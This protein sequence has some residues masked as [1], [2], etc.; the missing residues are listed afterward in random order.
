MTPGMQEITI[1]GQTNFRGQARVFGIYQEDRRGHIYVIGKTGVGKSTLMRNMLAQDIARGKGV[2]LVDPHGDLATELLEAIPGNRIN[3]VV[4]FDPSDADYPIGF[5]VLEAPKSEHKFLV[6]SGLVGT[7]K[8]IWADSWGPRLEYILRNAILALLDYP[9]ATMLGI[10]RMLSDKEY[11]ARVVKKI[12]DP[13]VKSFWLNEFANYSERFANEAISPVQNKVGQFLSSAII[14]NIVG[15]PKSTLDIAEIMNQGKV[16]IMNLSKGKIG[17][18]NSALLGAMMI[19]RLQLTAMDRASI[20]EAERKDFYLYVDEFQ[21]FATES[22]AGILS[23]ARKYH[24]NLT[25]AHQYIAQMEEAVRDAVFGNVGTLVTYR[26]G[27]YDAEYLEKEFAPN[28]SQSD[29]VNLDRYN[30]YVRLMING[31]TSKPFSM[32]NIPPQPFTEGNKE[33]VMRVSRERYASRRDMVEDRIMRW[34]A[35]TMAKVARVPMKEAPKP[36]EKAAPPIS[37]K[38]RSTLTASPPAPAPFPAVFPQI[39]NLEETLADEDKK[40]AAAR[41]KKKT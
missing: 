15:Q 33:K 30:A 23:E 17:E 18:D 2:A 34:S 7:L 8:K 14:R 28:F 38:A 31:V 40:R 32:R 4:Y 21:N 11:R 20:P 39:T 16:L 35:N 9:N 6:A 37:Q 24:L 26:V 29:L 13:V 1:L 3:D 41:Q 22:F 27:A 10:S 25:I 5:N 12:Q 19:T 36:P